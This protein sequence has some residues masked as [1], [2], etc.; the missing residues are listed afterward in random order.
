MSSLFYYFFNFFA[1]YMSSDNYRITTTVMSGGGTPMA[2]ANYQMN[3]TIGQPTPLMEQ[4]MDPF[5]DN[6]GLL[7]GFWY[8]IGPFSATCPEISIGTLM[9]MVPTFRNTSTILVGL[10]WMCL[11]P[12]LERRVVHNNQFHRL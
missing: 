8:T 5:S 3:G 11:Q 12:I 7:P 2:S 1:E 9:W 6:Y 4:G 10:A